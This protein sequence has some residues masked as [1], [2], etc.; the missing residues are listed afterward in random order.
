M[1]VLNIYVFQL[2]YPMLRLREEGFTT[3]S[4]G[5]EKGKD[6]K[7][8]HGYPCKS[9]KGIEEITAQVRP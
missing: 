6:Y 1:Q 2:W 5:P 8:K 3:F 7:S 9:D 4:V